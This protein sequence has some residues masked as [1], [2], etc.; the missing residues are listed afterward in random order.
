MIIDPFDGIGIFV[1]SQMFDKGILFQVLCFV[2][3]VLCSV[4]MSAQFALSLS[5]KSICRWISPLFLSRVKFSANVGVSHYGWSYNWHCSWGV[6]W[7]S[8]VESINVHSDQQ[9]LKFMLKCWHVLLCMYVKPSKMP[10][11]YREGTCPCEV[12]N[13]EIDVMSWLGL[14]GRC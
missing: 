10:Y 14:S 9:I 1:F 4:F 3:T 13:Q 11:F 6:R 5:S 12:V 2:R 7:G 8:H